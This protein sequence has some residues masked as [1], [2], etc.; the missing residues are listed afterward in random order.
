MDVWAFSPFLIPIVAILGAFSVAIVGTIMR[1]RVRELEIRERIAMIERG[2]VPPP[3]KD[4]GGF[5][6]AMRF[7]RHD[8]YHHDPWGDD[9]PGT[10]QR[11][12]RSV[13]VVLIGIGLGLMV[14]LTFAAR[15]TGTAIGVGGLL[16]IMGLAFLLNSLFGPSSASDL[17]ATP[18]HDSQVP[19]PSGS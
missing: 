5:D 8:R 9:R 1:A 10:G 18:P 19:P 15:D 14:L 4:P 11:R 16:V 17:P 12:H 7:D 2:L 13:G 3:E 6:R